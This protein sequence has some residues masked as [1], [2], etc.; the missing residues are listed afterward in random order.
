[1]EWSTLGDSECKEVG[2]IEGLV[3]TSSVNATEGVA[4]GTNDSSVLGALLCMVMG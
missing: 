2:L 3:D 4:L 1:M